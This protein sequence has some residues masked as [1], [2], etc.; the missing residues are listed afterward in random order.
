MNQ[1]A[2]CIQDLI[3]SFLHI[4]FTKTTSFKNVLN[5]ITFAQTE[6]SLYFMVDCYALIC[7]ERMK[8][9]LTHEL[10]MNNPE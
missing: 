2:E 6:C 8:N 10:L 7:D 1:N 3:H 9:E 5:Y 4:V